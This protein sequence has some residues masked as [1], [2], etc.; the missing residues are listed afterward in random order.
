M[1]SLILNFENIP[2]NTKLPEDDLKMFLE[3]FSLSFSSQFSSSQ[4]FFS[5]VF[6]MV[7]YFKDQVPRFKFSYSNTNKLSSFPYNENLLRFF[8][9]KLEEM[10][11]DKPL[12]NKYSIDYGMNDASEYYLMCMAS[13]NVVTP[14]S[15]TPVNSSNSS[16]SRFVSSDDLDKV[17]SFI[18]TIKKD[19]S[20]STLF[21]SIINNAKEFIPLSVIKSQLIKSLDRIIPFDPT[22]RVSK[23]VSMDNVVPMEK[24]YDKLVKKELGDLSITDLLS[25]M[26]RGCSNT[27]N[28]SCP[29]CEYVLVTPK[30]TVTPNISNDFDRLSA[31]TAKDVSC[32]QVPLLRNDS[33][34]LSKFLV[35]YNGRRFSI[36]SALCDDQYRYF[37]NKFIDVMIE[38]AEIV[39]DP[40]MNLEKSSYVK[41][42]YKRNIPPLDKSPP[43]SSV[44]LY[45][46]YIAKGNYSIKIDDPG[47][48]SH[49]HKVFIDPP[50]PN[51][52]KIDPIPTPGKIELSTKEKLVSIY[53]SQNKVFDFS[54]ITMELVKDGATYKFLTSEG[55]YGDA[56]SFINFLLEFYGVDNFI[57]LVITQI[58]D[59]KLP[60]TTYVSFVEH[61]VRETPTMSLLIEN[62]YVARVVLMRL[63]FSYYC[64][65]ERNSVPELTRELIWHLKGNTKQKFVKS[66][67]P[68]IEYYT[69]SEDDDREALRKAVVN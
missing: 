59:N 4:I 10:I 5:T 64:N 45:D 17:S 32:P 50:R 65:P 41:R 23:S 42:R 40:E 49:L 13:D 22:N 26:N 30:P 20:L 67:I 2:S 48:I 1:N 66:F 69:L 52:V 63:L 8:T 25:S 9:L 55:N 27:C 61:I 44:S 31:S 19:T 12:Y 53:S 51:L 6:I 46:Q 34:Y 54:K 68:L 43:N 62:R 28:I 37:V 16:S 18:V 47:H 24:S 58:T 56:E 7:K 36:D 60:E 11:R 57:K 15:D 14:R 39:V 3:S 33:F 21:D 38:K 29:K 35:I